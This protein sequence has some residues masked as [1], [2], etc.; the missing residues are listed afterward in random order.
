[1]RGGIRYSQLAT[2]IASQGDTVIRID[3]T[4]ESSLERVESG[5][6]GLVSLLHCDLI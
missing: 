6:Y 2:T 3:E 5:K 1:M 4:L